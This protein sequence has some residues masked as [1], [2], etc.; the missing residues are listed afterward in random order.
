MVLRSPYDIVDAGDVARGW[1]GRVLWVSM[2]ISE[3]P[4]T[5]LVELIDLALFSH[6]VGLEAE[7]A[8]TISSVRAG[9]IADGPTSASDVPEQLSTRLT[10]MEA[11]LTMS[12]E[13]G[14]R[15]RLDP[16]PDVAGSETE[17]AHRQSHHRPTTIWP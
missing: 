11:C 6:S 7:A 16:N 9:C 4:I 8:P 1:L 10:M 15:T 3:V 12:L 5:P 13:R 17:S 2:P 14:Q